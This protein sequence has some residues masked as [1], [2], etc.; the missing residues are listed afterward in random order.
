MQ[1]NIPIWM[2]VHPSQTTSNVLPKA[3]DQLAIAVSILVMQQHNAMLV[4]N[5]C[6]YMH[7]HSYMY[8]C[9]HIIL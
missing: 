9:V 8:M 5:A 3:L 6:M 2:Q 7:V 4:D 1:N